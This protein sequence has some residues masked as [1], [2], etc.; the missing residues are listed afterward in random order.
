MNSRLFLLSSLS[1]VV[2]FGFIA[3]LAA[4]GDDVTEVTNIYQSGL[5][6]VDSVKGLP[7]C[8]DENEGQ[9]AWVK[10]EPSVRICSDGEW[11]ALSSGEGS[12]SDFA[13]KTEELADGSGLKIV[14]NGDSIGVVL[15]GS[16]GKDGK[17][18]KDGKDGDDGK[19]AVLP[20]DTAA[21]DSERV[22]VSLDSLVGYAY[23]FLKGS[24]V[25]LYELSDGRTLKQANV[26]V[27]TSYI[28]HDDYRY[29]FIARELASQYA[30]VVVEGFFSNEGT[31]VAAKTPI[32]L[33]A[34]AD[35]R[36]R[37]SVNVNILTHLEFERVF[38]LV[39]KG[40]STG[41]KLTVK[42]A[43][44]QAQKEIL[45]FFHMKL[46]KDTNAED[47]HVFGASEADAALLAIT[48]LLRTNRTD[49]E[50]Q[51]MLSEISAELAET[52]KWEDDRADSIRTSMADWTFSREKLRFQSNMEDLRLS[53]KPVGNFEKF[54]EEFV[55][56]NF[57]I[58][59]C[60]G[61]STAK[62]EIRNTKSIFNGRKYE[63]FQ[64]STL[65]H[66]TWV[67]I[68][69][70]YPYLNKNV[71]YRY[72]IDWRDRRMYKTV[73]L[74]SIFHNSVKIKPKYWAFAENLDFEYRVYGKPY[75]LACY[76]GDC[77]S[78][79]SRAFGL[80]YTLNAAK[81]FATLYSDNYYTDDYAAKRGICPED[82]YIP[83]AQ[84]LEIIVKDARKLDDGSMNDSVAAIFKTTTGWNGENGS[85]STGFSAYPAGF[86]YNSSTLEFLANQGRE[87]YA[88]SSV[89]NMAVFWTS[90]ES[91]A[92]K[93]LDSTDVV[94]LSEPNLMGAYAAPVRCFNGY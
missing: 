74:G 39:T 50:L 83:S 47:M 42:Q 56:G 28:T 40:D 48:I 52:G 24:T 7:K 20:N 17:A 55:A 61:V 38:H 29:K 89:G 54:L 34:I 45:D 57:G 16:D 69:R 87:N 22:P 76:K 70:D 31:G 85:N 37:D 13:C 33:K 73:G 6:V 43:K 75:G 67:D 44:L 88:P 8:T 93:L 11:F 36:N 59:V 86:S 62:Q 35:M 91:L 27:G 46:D 5:E 68:R 63:C 2:A 65:T 32:R 53:G 14:C 60:E 19:D 90:S 77:N 71:E 4:C 30:V 64:D 79:S 3:F 25:Y 84:M 78:D 92:F 1:H 9:Q 72:V 18:G 80:F 49:F 66:A 81:D 12:D 23:P 41:K 15:N 51:S 26:S 58:K 94:D 82:W 21:T 10:G